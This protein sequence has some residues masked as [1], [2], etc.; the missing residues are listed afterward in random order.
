MV[1]FG[2]SCAEYW[3]LKPHKFSVV[4]RYPVRHA[5]CPVKVSQ[6]G[7]SSAAC[8]E[9]H[10]LMLAPSRKKFVALCCVTPDMALFIWPGTA[11]RS[12]QLEVCL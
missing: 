2:H 12:D 7:C 1:I 8:L 6:E 5:T 4:P 11:I 3:E 9:N 10:I